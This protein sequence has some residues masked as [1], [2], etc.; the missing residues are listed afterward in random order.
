MQVQV[1]V[2]T[3]SSEPVTP[4]ERRLH[5]GRFTADQVRQSS[6][7]G[8]VERFREAAAVARKIRKSRTLV[9]L[10]DAYLDYLL[11]RDKRSTVSAPRDNFFGDVL[12]D[13]FTSIERKRKKIV[14]KG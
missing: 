3:M 2:T 1:Q 11:L 14:R 7:A 12:Y 5:E 9:D 10:C 8:D 6:N 13:L 4:F